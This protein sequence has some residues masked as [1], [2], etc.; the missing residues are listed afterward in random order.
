MKSPR[1]VLVACAVLG[2]L[3]CRS[4]PPRPPAP[5]DAQPEPSG[6]APPSRV[7]GAPNNPPGTAHPPLRARWEDVLVDDDCKTD[8]KTGLPCPREGSEK[9]CCAGK[10]DCKG[11]SGCRSAKNGCKGRNTCKGQGTSC[12]NVPTPGADRP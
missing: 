3:A 6:A 11:Q 5:V 8:P 7:I 12:P 10:N 9:N 1:H 4:T 2:A